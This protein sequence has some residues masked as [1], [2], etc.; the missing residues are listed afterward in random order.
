MLNSASPTIYNPEKIRIVRK[1][2]SHVSAKM[3]DRR[4]VKYTNAWNIVINIL[5]SF[6]VILRVLERYFCRFGA[7]P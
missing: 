2:P 7:M 1:E 6:D 5:A 4:G 3:A